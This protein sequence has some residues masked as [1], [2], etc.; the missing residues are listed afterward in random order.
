MFNFRRIKLLDSRPRIHR[1]RE[2]FW[3]VHAERIKIPRSRIIQQALNELHILG[4]VHYIAVFAVK[5]NF[6]GVFSGRSPDATLQPGLTRQAKTGAARAR[7]GGTDGAAAAVFM[8]ATA[9]AGG[10]YLVWMW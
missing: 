9:L 6:H 7:G 10:A 1:K 8:A 4:R 3:R 2:T 5:H